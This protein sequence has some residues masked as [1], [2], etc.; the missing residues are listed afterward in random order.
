M[1]H[2]LRESVQRVES[3]QVTAIILTIVAIV[4]AAEL[5]SAWMRG[6]IARAVA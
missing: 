6:R 3:R 4:I 5:F 2:Y 1:G